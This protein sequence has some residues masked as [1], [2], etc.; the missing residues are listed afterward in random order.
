MKGRN[1]NENPR[2]NGAY[3]AVAVNMTV[4]MT[5]TTTAP[6][7]TCT[8]TPSALPLNGAGPFNV[9]AAVLTTASSAGLMALPRLSTYRALL[10]LS[11]P[12]GMGLI[13]PFGSK[14]TARRSRMLR[15]V[16]M[17]CVLSAGLFLPNCGGSSG[18]G[19]GGSTGTPQGTYQ[20]TVTG[21]YKSG[22]THLVHAQ[23]FML[24]VE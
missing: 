20:V 16:R 12:L 17:M 19:G 3:R 5:C 10:A 1:E 13:V 6:K 11:F 21:T 9:N 14:R 18:G 22:P 4:A 7:S 24:L 8:A 15:L 23:A 2:T